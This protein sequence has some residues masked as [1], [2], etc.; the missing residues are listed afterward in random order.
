MIA[1]IA[2]EYQRLDSSG[3]LPR[4]RQGARTRTVPIFS[5]QLVP[6]KIFDGARPNLSLN[7]D[8]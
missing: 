6:K 3:L 1:P 5:R 2:E 8:F 7:I 4:Q